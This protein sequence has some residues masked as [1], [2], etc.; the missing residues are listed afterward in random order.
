MTAS[1]SVHCKT[2]A[3][4]VNIAWHALLPT[5]TPTLDSSRN[6]RRERERRARRDRRVEAAQNAYFE[7]LKSD[8]K[9][10]DIPYLPRPHACTQF[11]SLLTLVD[12]DEEEISTN[13]RERL[14]VALHEALPLMQDAFKKHLTE[15][16]SLIQDLDESSSDP[17][18]ILS[19]ATS[20][21]VVRDRYHLQSARFG[22]EAVAFSSIPNRSYCDSRISR[23]SRHTPDSTAVKA[24]K[25][26]LSILKLEETTT[27]LELDV[28]D[29]CFT[30]TSCPIHHDPHYIHHEGAL[31]SV[32]YRAAMNW[33]DVVRCTVA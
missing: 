25:A 24:V 2:V 30:C 22:L 5:L 21:L 29:G 31:L 12:E 11:G 1:G 4:A 17:A 19:L 15:F 33:R 7:L 10:R 26:I 6:L 20:V 16:A 28:L 13:W 23:V 9:P 27:I 14:D 18:D 8:V 32:Q 3:D